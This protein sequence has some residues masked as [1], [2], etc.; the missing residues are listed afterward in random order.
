MSSS[1]P[2]LVLCVCAWMS[3]GREEE[4][5]FLREKYEAGNKRGVATFLC[6][7]QDVFVWVCWFVCVCAQ[8]CGTRFDSEKMQLRI[9][10][11]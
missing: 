10:I 6:A 1:P 8:V 9:E 2:K 5:V 7:V 11:P 4:K 3:C